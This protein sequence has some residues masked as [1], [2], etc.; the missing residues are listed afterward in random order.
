MT[1][2]FIIQSNF[3]EEAVS[4]SSSA[5]VQYPYLVKH[6]ITIWLGTEP[7]FSWKHR[8][9]DPIAASVPIRTS[10]SALQLV[11]TL[12]SSVPLIWGGVLGLWINHNS[13][14]QVTLY[15]EGIDST[16]S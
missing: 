14:K 16:C 12:S 8:Y 6:Q 15:D 1:T 3:I 7:I 11:A 9:L 4:P 2:S 10:G 5:R 13:E